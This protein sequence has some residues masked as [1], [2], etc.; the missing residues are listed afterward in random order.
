MADLPNTLLFVP[1]MTVVFGFAGLVVL[2]GW[3]F[4]RKEIPTS[5]I[6]WRLVSQR[7]MNGIKNLRLNEVID[8]LDGEGDEEDY[9][10]KA[11][12]LKSSGIFAFQKKDKPSLKKKGVASFLA[13]G[14]ARQLGVDYESDMKFI[15][16]SLGD[17]KV[18]VVFN[19]EKGE[20][21]IKYKT[22][23]KLLT[24]WHIIFSKQMVYMFCR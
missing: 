15:E 17:K 1:L 14:E 21:T 8:F 11:E 13:L 22:D 10:M 19:K 23:Q 7:K 9:V 3:D 18:G 20:I 12:S 6:E 4:G 2:Y 16:T 5:E 24:I